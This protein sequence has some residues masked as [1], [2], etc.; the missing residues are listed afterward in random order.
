MAQSGVWVIG[1]HYTIIQPGGTA[2]GGLLFQVA[3]YAP[4]QQQTMTPR[5]LAPGS[6]TVELR[7]AGRMLKTEKLIVLP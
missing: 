2:M 7:N 5:R 3:Q 1:D 4:E 6:Y